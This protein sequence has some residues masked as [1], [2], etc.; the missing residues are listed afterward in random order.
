MRRD[1]QPTQYYDDG[2]EVPARGPDYVSRE[3]DGA[4]TINLDGQRHRIFP[5]SGSFFVVYK[6][7]TSAEFENFSAYE[8]ASKVKK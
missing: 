1:E 5:G 8:A 3:A 6:D 4:Y 7:G 2:S